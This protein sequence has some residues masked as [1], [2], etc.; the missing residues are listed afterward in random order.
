MRIRNK[1]CYAHNNNDEN[2]TYYWDELG[3]PEKSKII[4]FSPYLDRNVNRRY[5]RD[6][7]DDNIGVDESNKIASLIVKVVVKVVLMKIH[8]DIRR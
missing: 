3:F 1:V 8:E 7:G 6:D 4:K 2:D 5:H